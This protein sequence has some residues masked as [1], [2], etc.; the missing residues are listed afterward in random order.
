MT[1]EDRTDRI[2]DRD[3]TA[4]PT[5]A[6]QA[7]VRTTMRGVDRSRGRLDDR[8]V[9]VAVLLVTATIG[10]LVS[11]AFVV[12][13]A[14]IYDHVAE[15]E[16]VSGFDRPVLDWVA[17]RRTETLD[18]LVSHYTD[19]GGT[20]L[21]PVI[22]AASAIVL[23]AWWRRWT[24]ILL[25][26]VAAGGS[27]TLTIVGKQAIGRARPPHELAVPPYETSPSFP[28]GHTLNSWV[29]FLLTAYLVCCKLEDRRW[30][31]AAVVVGVALAVAM[32][33]S[34]VYLGH[35]WLT[36]VLVAWALGLG[37]LAVV[38]TAHRLLLTVRRRDSDTGRRPGTT[39]APSKG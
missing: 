5:R 37:W 28:S 25:M 18:A 14:E 1:D 16:G 12:L 35:H 38:I 33:L 11:A 23:A 19:L 6:G 8:S 22:A 34:R 4:W 2:G 9:P 20:V 30:R 15:R 39:V 29:I 17:A 21:M 3:L 31:V 10:V 7:V 27:L 26:A 36:D 32:G 13:S 24:P